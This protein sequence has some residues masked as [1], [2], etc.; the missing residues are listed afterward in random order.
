MNLGDDTE[1]NGE[2]ELNS[3]SFAQTK[4]GCLDENAIGAQVS[5]AT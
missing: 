3:G 5:G 4:V 2:S 1:V